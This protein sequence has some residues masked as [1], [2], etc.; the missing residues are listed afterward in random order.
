MTL[1]L[2]FCLKRRKGGEEE[3][4]FTSW[5]KWSKG[6]SIVKLKLSTSGVFLFFFK[7][8]SIMCS[9]FIPNHILLYIVYS[10]YR[11][12]FG[13]Y[14]LMFGKIKRKIQLNIFSTFCSLNI[15]EISVFSRETMRKQAIKH[16]FLCFC[17]S[18]QILWNILFFKAVIVK[19]WSFF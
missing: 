17:F 8:K 13:L 3:Q 2:N 4:D 5:F 10:S 6:S 1:G 11:Y 16:V 15:W 18:L 14:A 9:E 12:S 19:L 7:H